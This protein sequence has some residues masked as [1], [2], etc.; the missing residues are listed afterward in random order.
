MDPVPGQMLLGNKACNSAIHDQGRRI[1][2]PTGIHHRQADRHGHAAGFL[3]NPPQ[4]LQCRFVHPDRVK[5]VF[6]AISADAQ[7]GQTQHTGLLLAGHSNRR[8][9]IVQIAQPVQG[10]L[11]DRCSGDSDQLHATVCTQM[12]FIANL[13]S[14]RW[15]RC[16]IYDCKPIP[17][18][19]RGRTTTT[20]RI[21]SR[22]FT[23][24]AIR[25][26]QYP[27]SLPP[28]PGNTGRGQF[29]IRPASR[30]PKMQFLFASAVGRRCGCQ[31][32]R[33]PV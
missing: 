8:K 21:F 18:S 24:A 32:V 25:S 12:V 7:F 4:K 30:L 6:A 33:R 11:V 19:L 22:R 20:W 29:A 2:N 13:P 1:K 28:V 9:D 31:L 23:S 16:P 17:V 5:S 14:V 3:Q 10:R 27:R 15:K 26:V